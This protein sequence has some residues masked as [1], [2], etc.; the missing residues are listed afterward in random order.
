MGKKPA[1]PIEVHVVVRDESVV[2]RGQIGG[3]ADK[4]EKGQKRPS[5][6]QTVQHL[7]F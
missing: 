1:C 7:T 4:G 2:K 3:E 5:R 6:Q